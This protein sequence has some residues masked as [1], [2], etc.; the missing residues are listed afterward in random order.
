ML[1]ADEENGDLFA[2]F[3]TSIAAVRNEE[4][5]C[6]VTVDIDDWN[7]GILR[8]VRQPTNQHISESVAPLASIVNH[9]SNFVK[10][11]KK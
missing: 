9:N 10:N 8:E 4:S 1:T 3:D 6:L 2:W 5:T 11:F 7:R